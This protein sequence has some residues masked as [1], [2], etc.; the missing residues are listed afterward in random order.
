[1]Y[2]IDSIKVRIGVLGTYVQTFLTLHY[3]LAHRSSAR[4]LSQRLFTMRSGRLDFGEECPLS[5]LELVSE[6]RAFA[7]G[8]KTDKTEN[9]TS[10]R[11]LLRHI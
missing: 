2:P 3:R 4:S 11:C 8:D 7:K 5:L 6:V 9:R 10:T 1:M